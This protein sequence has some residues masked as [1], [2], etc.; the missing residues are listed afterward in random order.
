MMVL[1]DFR[2]PLLKI[3][4]CFCRKAEP[5]S[6]HQSLRLTQ[7]TFIYFLGLRINFPGLCQGLPGPCQSAEAQFRLQG[8]GC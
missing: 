5:P 2:C 7:I 1:D 3:F 4:I 6:A 8:A